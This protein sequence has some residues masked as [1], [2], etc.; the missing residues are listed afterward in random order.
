MEDIFK[1]MSGNEILGDLSIDLGMV[2]P[3]EAIGQNN[4]GQWRILL[5]V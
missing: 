5:R 2:V 1:A 3:R 4:G